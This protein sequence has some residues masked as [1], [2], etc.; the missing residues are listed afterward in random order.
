MNSGQL[1]AVGTS[2]AVAPVSLRDALAMN[3]KRARRFLA[4]LDSALPEVA[5]AVVL[6]TCTRTEIYL[7]TSDASA[8]ERVHRRLVDRGRDATPSAGRHIYLLK[9]ESAARHAFRVAAGLDSI[10]LGE[11]Q[12]LGQVKEARHLAWSEGTC[13]TILCQLFDDAVRCGKRIRTETE[14]NR[15]SVS[16]ASA[17]VQNVRRHFEDLGDRTVL[18]LGA[19]ET[20]ALAARMLAKL[21]PGRLLLVN[22]T[23]RRAEA[24]AR[25]L[26]GEAW[27][28]GDIA[29]ALEIADAAVCATASADPIITM[30]LA[31]RVHHARAGRPLLLVDIANPRDVAP[32][33]ASYAGFDLLDLDAIE[34]TVTGTHERRE[35]EVPR[36]E[37]IVE[38]ELAVF[39]QWL[40][41][42][43]VVPLLRSLREAFHDIGDEVLEA[44]LR[45]LGEEHREAVSQVT[46]RVINKLLHTPTVNLKDLDL[47]TRSD[48]LKL[49]ALEEL[50]GLG[51]NAAA[52]EH[53]DSASA[54]P[55][56]RRLA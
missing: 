44:E 6:S 39:L 37:E 50:F 17:A 34:A 9:G 8:A 15:G 5:E 21:D 22:R 32:G 2:H 47:S 49:R 7:V 54:D 46:R 24:L 20:G 43:H 36:A 29:E 31:G 13:G 56:G 38:E 30:D 12:V 51:P 28:L 53:P 42:R 26:G 3:Q 11:G 10:V 41:S 4:E 45:R 16:I 14:L 1:F 48:A 35:K 52:S 40:D 55:G 19:G 33:V 18:V 25:E 27:A 23:R